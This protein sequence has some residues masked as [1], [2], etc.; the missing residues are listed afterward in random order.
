MLNPMRDCEILG[1]IEAGS[2]PLRKGSIIKAYRF[3]TGE[4]KM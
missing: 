4:C 2:P 1:E 3:L